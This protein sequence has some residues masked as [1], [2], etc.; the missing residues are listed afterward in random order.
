M[1]GT[2]QLAEIENLN[3]CPI[4]DSK[5]FTHITKAFVNDVNYLDTVFCNDCHFVFRQKRPSLIWWKKFWADEQ[6][7]NI[8][9]VSINPTFRDTFRYKRYSNLEKIFKKIVKNHNVLDIGTSTGFGLKAFY[10][11]GWGVQGVEPVTVA[12][13]FAKRLGLKIYNESVETFTKNHK[14]QY[15]LV[16]LIHALEHFHYPKSSLQEISKLVRNEGY[17]YVEVPNLEESVDYRDALDYHH[18]NVF[19]KD[20]LIKLLSQIGFKPILHLKTKSQPYGSYHMGILAKKS[21][22]HQTISDVKKLYIP[23]N[24]I[25]KKYMHGLPRNYNTIEFPIKYNV[26]SMFDYKIIGMIPHKNETSWQLIYGKKQDLLKRAMTRN[27][28]NF[29]LNMLSRHSHLIKDMNFEKFR[30]EYLK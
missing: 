26:S 8:S 28:I 21:L 24:E 12:A 29:V 20:V 4:C 9:N 18:V 5:K 6:N 17:L 30:I 1:N 7:H 11:N 19:S 25:K 10:D 3:E 15:E 27:S 14:Q 23:Y 22:E 13:S 16:L 2:I